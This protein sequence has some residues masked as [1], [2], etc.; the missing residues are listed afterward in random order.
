MVELRTKNL[1]KSGHVQLKEEFNDIRGANHYAS[2]GV[3][4]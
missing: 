1:K 4:V 3:D 2:F